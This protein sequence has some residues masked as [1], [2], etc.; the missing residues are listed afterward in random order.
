MQGTRRAELLRRATRVPM[1][2]SSEPLLQ[3][4]SERASSAEIRQQDGK[5]IPGPAPPD[6]LR[7]ERGGD[8]VVAVDI[9]ASPKARKLSSYKRT[10]G[11]MIVSIVGAGVLGLPYAFRRSGWAF[12]ILALAAM[13]VVSF[14]GMLL[15]VKTRKLLE[16]Q[17][18]G[19]S[20]GPAFEVKEEGAG[21]TDPFH[22][23]GRVEHLSG[24]AGSSDLSTEDPSVRALMHGS[25]HEA[26]EPGEEGEGYFLRITS[27][28]ELGNRVMG[29]LGQVTGL[30]PNVH[31]C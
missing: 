8:G 26:K 18:R 25:K 12:S 9:V 2:Q 6:D 27:Y 5:G 17:S 30:E 19:Q 15:L 1:E 28:G 16:A 3:Q 29:T 13:A 14:Y 31:K 22:A 4:A 11:N 24:E 21:D 23:D 20:S 7:E 10:L